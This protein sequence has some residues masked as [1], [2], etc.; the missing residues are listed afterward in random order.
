MGWVSTEAA[1]NFNAYAA[2]TVL[3]LWTI[4]GI[5][6]GHTRSLIDNIITVLIGAMF[7]GIAAGSWSAAHGQDPALRVGYFTALLSLTVVALGWRLFE[8]YRK[9]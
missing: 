4:N 7:F 8:F 3:A 9:P 5:V 1:R 2:L 6:F